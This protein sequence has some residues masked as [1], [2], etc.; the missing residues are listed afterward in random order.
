MG[1]I[2][3]GDYWGIKNYDPQLLMENGGTFDFK[4]GVSCLIVN[5]ERGIE[6]LE[7]FGGTLQKA[8]IEIQNVMK[9]N[10]QL[11][12]PAKHTELRN[13]IFSLYTK[14]GYSA[15]EKLFRRQQFRRN[16][17]NKIK[18]FIKR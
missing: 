5:D 11:R 2:T 8:P 10:K 3:I 12:E 6:L 15:V 9:I 14:K 7:K 17:K 13:K 4:Q 1:D 18:A 16:I